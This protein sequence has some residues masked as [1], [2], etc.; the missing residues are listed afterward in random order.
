MA[1]TQR[2]VYSA[3]AEPVARGGRWKLPRLLF[4]LLLPLAHVGFIL[5]RFK[6]YTENK[7]Q[8]PKCF[9]EQSI[10]KIKAT[11]IGGGTTANSKLLSIWDFLNRILKCFPN[12]LES[13][14]VLG[15]LELSQNGVTLFQSSRKK[16]KESKTFWKDRN[17]MKENQITTAPNGF[18]FPF[19]CTKSSICVYIHKYTCIHRHTHI[20]SHSVHYRILA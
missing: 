8:W 13:S 10:V 14:S 9:T 4:L 18:E 11:C 7:L 5:Y 17:K 2:L 12:N 3:R 19:S 20:I 16:M 15:W 6:S 1:L